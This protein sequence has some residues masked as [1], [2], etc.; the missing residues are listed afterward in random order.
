[1]SNNFI[2]K[3]NM[4]NWMLKNKIPFSGD[5][6]KTELHAPI[7]LHTLQNTSHRVINSIK[8]RKDKLSVQTQLI[9]CSKGFGL[10]MD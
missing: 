2:K 10:M 1:V 6:L 3:E 5:L 4:E 8:E 7:K 9:F